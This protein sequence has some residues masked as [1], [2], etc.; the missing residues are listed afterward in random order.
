MSRFGNVNGSG[1]WLEDYGYDMNPFA[2]AGIFCAKERGRLMKKS[3]VFLALLI[4][5][6][7][8][9]SLCAQTK[10]IAVAYSAIS[11]TQTGF[12]LAKDAKIIGE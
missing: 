3:F 2:G 8:D 7:L 10:R 5:L 12:Y 9:R 4:V 6:F 11:A 1:Y